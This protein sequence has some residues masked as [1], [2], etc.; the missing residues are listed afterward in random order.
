M[1]WEDATECS[2][3]LWYESFWGSA[4]DKWTSLSSHSNSRG[5]TSWENTQFFQHIAWERL[6]ARTDEASLPQHAALQCSSYTVHTSEVKLVIL[7]IKHLSLICVVLSIWIKKSH[8]HLFVL[9]KWRRDLNVNLVHG[10]HIFIKSQNHRMVGVGRDLWGSSGP[11]PLPKQGH[12]QQAAQDCVQVDLEYLQRRR[13]HNLP[14]Q[15]VPGLCHPQR[16]EI[17]RHVQTELPVLL[18][19]C[20]NPLV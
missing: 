13:I 4:S 12:L 20:L 14:G 6:L 3:A 16:E 7:G 9:F 15:T 1:A 5:K 2:P 17:L 18:K 19:S 8:T 10:L 11:P